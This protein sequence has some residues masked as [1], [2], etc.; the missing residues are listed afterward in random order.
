MD[1]KTKILNLI[2]ATFLLATSAINFA[3]NFV[4]VPQWLLLSGTLFAIIE[5][6]LLIIV[7]V[8]LIRY[9]KR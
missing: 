5:G 9:R 8:R 4:N 7:S 3:R 1:N 2:F 6:I